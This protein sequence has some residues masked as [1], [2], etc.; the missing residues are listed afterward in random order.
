M[1]GGADKNVRGGGQKCPRP[2][3]SV[4]NNKSIINSYYSFDTEKEEEEKTGN[5]REMQER[6]KCYTVEEVEA[7]IRVQNFLDEFW[8]KIGSV[9]DLRNSIAEMLN[10]YAENGKAIPATLAESRLRA[11]LKPKYE[12]EDDR[13]EMKKATKRAQKRAQISEAIRHTE[14][15]TT[16]E[17]GTKEFVF[18]DIPEQ[19][20][21]TIFNEATEAIEKDPKFRLI[22]SNAE[23][24]N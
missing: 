19:Y 3:Y 20:R 14:K 2:T 22:L 9:D 5:N 4:F 10:H 24:K 6:E 17:T 15:E 21:E 8:Y 23:R 13:E 18:D 7:R 12:T 1:S 16:N 11:W